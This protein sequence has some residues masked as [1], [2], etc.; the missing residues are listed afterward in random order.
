MY[1][2]S[3]LTCECIADYYFQAGICTLC[4]TS[5]QLTDV[6]CRCADPLN[7]FDEY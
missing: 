1:F 5:R 2:S 6:T 4:V 3:N 7:I